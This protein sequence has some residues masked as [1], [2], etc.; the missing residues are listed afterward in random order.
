MSQEHIEKIKRLTQLLRFILCVYSMIHSLRCRPRLPLHFHLFGQRLPVS[1]IH[2]NQDADFLTQKQFTGDARPCVD[3]RVADS[4]RPIGA[5]LASGV[6]LPEPCPDMLYILADFRLVGVLVS[7][8]EA[9][10]ELPTGEDDFRLRPV[11]EFVSR[12]FPLCDLG[13]SGD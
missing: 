7:L 13:D 10:V 5:V 4:L 11:V 6:Q 12:S 2:P 9:L 3:L 1:V 8:V